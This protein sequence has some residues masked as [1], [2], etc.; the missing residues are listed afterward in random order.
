MT[1]RQGIRISLAFVVVVCA[2]WGIASARAESWLQPLL[3]IE[4]TVRHVAAARP[5]PSPLRRSSATSAEKIAELERLEAQGKFST[6]I[7]LDLLAFLGAERAAPLRIRAAHTFYLI[8]YNTAEQGD[9]VA[10][11]LSR[12]DVRARYVRL[13]QATEPEIRRSLLQTAQ[14]MTNGMSPSV[15]LTISDRYVHVLLDAVRDDPL[16]ELRNEALVALD[17]LRDSGV[18]S[19]ERVQ[20]RLQ[21]LGRSEP[22]DDIKAMIRDLLEPEVT[23]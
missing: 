4:Q 23:H 22:D 14:I 16:P 19:G 12:P 9:E 3:D 8:F 18:L 17:N 6:P 20:E 13:L 11:L 7:A 21:E 15:K 1:S 5:Q 10:S 2:V